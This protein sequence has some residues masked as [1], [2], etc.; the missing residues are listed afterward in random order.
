MDH[1]NDS[2]HYFGRGSRYIYLGWEFFVRIRKIK[3][4]GKIIYFL[5]DLYLLIFLEVLCFGKKSLL[6]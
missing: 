6:S 5:K 1:F 2:V 4:C 3:I